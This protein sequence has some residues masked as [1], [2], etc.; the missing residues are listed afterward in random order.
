MRVRPL[1][2]AVTASIARGHSLCYMRSQVPAAIASLSEAFPELEA[3]QPLVQ[4]I[5]A[6]EEAS[7][8][9]MLSRGIKE[10]NARAQAIKATGEAGFDGQAALA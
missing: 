3:Q 4:R 9:S 7:F 10:F 6:E 8:S 1:L 5:I 2:H